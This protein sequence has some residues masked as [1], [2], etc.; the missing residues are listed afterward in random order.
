MQCVALPPKILQGIDKLNRNFIWDLFEN[1][2]KI[3]LIGW[4]KITKAKKEGGLGIQAA[5]PKNTALLA[6]LNC[7]FPSEKSSLW[8]RVLT[9]K[10]W[11]QGRTS[12]STTTFSSCSTTW[13]GL[14]KGEDIFFKGSKWI[15]CKDSLLFLWLDK[16]LNIGLLWSLISDPLKKGEENLMLK[17][18]S[19]FFG[20][21]WEGLSFELPTSIQLEMKATPLPFSN[22]GGDRLS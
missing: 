4:N 9:N 15:A 22:Q 13:A 2:K 18:I 19:S 1:K 20:W 10:Y 7:R 6:K 16:W 17:D 5:K 12:R 3:H 21:N 8:V 11:R 14:K